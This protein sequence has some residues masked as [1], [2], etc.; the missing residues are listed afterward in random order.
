MTEAHRLAAIRRESRRDI[1]GEKNPN[2][3]NLG[4]TSCLTCGKSI[5]RVTVSQPHKYCSRQC[6]QQSAQN[7][8]LGRLLGKHPNT[9]RRGRK[10][11]IQPVCE[12]CGVDRIKRSDCNTCGSAACIQA[13]RAKG[14][15]TISLINRSRKG[16]RKSEPQTCQQCNAPYY[17][18]KSQR[19]KFC[20][21]R[22]FVA[23]G[24]PQRAGKA[25]VTMAQRYGVKRDANHA[26]IVAA[27]EKIGCWVID[28][29]RL[30]YGMTDLIVMHK[31]V[32]RL[33]EIKNPKTGYGRRGLNPA[34]R[35][36]KEWVESHG[37][38]IHV[39]ES[40][41]DALRLHGAKV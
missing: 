20:S 31:G 2:W 7:I 36:F 12:Y 37:C 41:D 19:R 34:Q 38:T 14:A 30:G 16:I 15:A 25:A 24:G 4:Y 35:K 11:K 10:P 13:G 18:S 22:C 17:A 1:R 32:T 26:E 21:Y 3:R 28:T 40:V 27:L 33:V 5:N 29:S 8:E 23:S 39:V 9:K 6:K